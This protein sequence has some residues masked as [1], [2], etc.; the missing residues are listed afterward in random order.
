MA[1]ELGETLAD[2]LEDEILPCKA[3]TQSG[4]CLDQQRGRFLLREMKPRKMC[5][6]CLASWK[7]RVAMDGM[8]DLADAKT[9]PSSGVD[10]G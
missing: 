7:L 9:R 6:R 10:W 2:D 4:T 8:K 3:R 1:V 5:T